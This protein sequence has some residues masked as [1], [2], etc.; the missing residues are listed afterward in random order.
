MKNTFNYKSYK[1]NSQKNLT[2]RLE[3]NETAKNLFKEGKITL[4]EFNKI[5]HCAKF[6][7]RVDFSGICTPGSNGVKFGKLFRLDGNYHYV[8]TRGE[9]YGHSKV[10]TYKVVY[11]LENSE[12]IIA[13]YVYDGLKLKGKVDQLYDI[14]GMKI[15]WDAST[16]YGKKKLKNLWKTLFHYRSDFINIDKFIN[17]NF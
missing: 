11:Y 7:M 12:K 13:S 5:F 4:K 16:A 3:S 2:V 17:E 8:A 6:A 1:K 10:I 15:Q 9:Y 14:E